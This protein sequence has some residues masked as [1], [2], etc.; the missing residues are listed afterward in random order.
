MERVAVLER[1]LWAAW[2]RNDRTT[3]TRLSDSSYLSV[4]EASISGLAGIFDDRFHLDSYSLGPFFSFRPDANT[5]ILVYRANMTAHYDG[6]RG[7]IDLS[8]PVSECSVWIERKPHQWRNAML[9]ET[10]VASVRFPNAAPD[11]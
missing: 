4:N 6:P 2:Q 9:H 8:R 11:P 1:T 7:R 5:I 10:T 3:I